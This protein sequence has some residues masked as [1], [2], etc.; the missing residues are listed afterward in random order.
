[1]E[2]PTTPT[3]TRISRTGAS[4]SA[5][6]AAVT[7]TETSSPSAT[8]SGA[9]DK[10]TTLSSSVINNST[11]WTA[12]RSEVPR[13]VATRRLSATALSTG[14]ILNSPVAEPM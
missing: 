9:A 6:K 1:M 2:P 3:R 4:A 8:D 12:N 13:T 11:G 5:G 14:V 10:V 7:S